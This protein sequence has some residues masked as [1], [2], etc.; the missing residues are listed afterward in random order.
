MLAASSFPLS[1]MRRSDFEVTG[2]NKL[3]DRVSRLLQSA[4]ASPAVSRTA[5][6]MSDADRE[7][8]VV[9]TPDIK[10]RLA[11]GLFERTPLNSQTVNCA[12]TLLNI[13]SCLVCKCY[14]PKF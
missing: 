13:I 1:M 10:V 3:A 8:Q 6:G 11:A 7:R 5:S 2:S 14:L 12:L 9:H 4:A